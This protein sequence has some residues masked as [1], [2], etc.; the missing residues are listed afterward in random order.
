MKGHIPTF[1]KEREKWGTLQSEIKDASQTRDYCLAKY[2]R[3]SAAEL[4]RLRSGFRRAAQTPHNRL[5]LDRQKMAAR[6][7]NKYEADS[8]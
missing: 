6:D 7:D 5:N 3:R 4:P 1:R 8:E 2:A